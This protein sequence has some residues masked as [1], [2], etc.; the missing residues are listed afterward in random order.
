M[1]NGWGSPATAGER[2]VRIAAVALATVDGMLPENYARALRLGRIALASKPDIILFPEAF[3]AGY[4]GTDLAP[5]AEAVDSPH[6]RRLMELSREGGCLIVAGFLEKV[7]HGIR[8]TAAVYD[9]GARIGAHSKMSLWVDRE[10]PYRDE[11]A[12]MEPGAAIEVFATRLGRLAILICYE[13]VLEA[14]WDGI[15]GKAD[16]VLS[17]YNCEGDPSASNI[18]QA[19]RLGLPSAWADRTGTV[20]AGGTTYKPNLGTAG[21]VDASGTVI[22]RSA[23]GV[24]AIVEGVL[25]VAGRPSVRGT[26]R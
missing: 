19:R 10:R 7:A 8:N 15:A 6:Q 1:N 11:P 18:D 17:P 5:F 16:F 23:P 13:N 2:S 22:A 14:N 25:T 20:Y 24:E 4:F 21:L 9:R 3:A 12:L 26:P